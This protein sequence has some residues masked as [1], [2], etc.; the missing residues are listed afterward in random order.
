MLLNN[1]FN[2]GPDGT[3]LSTSNS[4]QFGDNAFDA[5]NI[6][7]GSTLAFA[8]CGINDLDR[9]TAQYA[10][11]AATAGGAAQ[12]PY[13]SWTSAMGNQ[14][15]V[16]TRFYLYFASIGATTHDQTLLQLRTSAAF[17]TN[18]SVVLTT[19]TTPIVLALVSNAAVTTRATV[20]PVANQWNRVEFFAN[21]NSAASTGTLRLYA[22][23][24]V[25]TNNITDSASQSSANYGY[26]FTD[27]IRLG[28]LGNTTDTFP[29]IFFSNWQ[30]N[31]IGWPGPAP[32]RQGL[33]VPM[34]NQPNPIA[35][36]M[37]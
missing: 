17:L 37:I 13:V 19:S 28:Q 21:V 30:V 31:N 8:D 2:G 33:G 4:G 10:L 6:S 22:G 9:P 27:T 3:S 12:Q 11:E 20:T 7:S 32:F 15:T 25:D 34:N 14:T 35:Q 29:S 5:V 16:Y 1:N 18:V 24:D 36:H 23:D 26:T